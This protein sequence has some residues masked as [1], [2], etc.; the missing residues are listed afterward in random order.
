MLCDAK[1]LPDTHERATT[2]YASY[3]RQFSEVLLAEPGEKN[4]N[5][6][7]DRMQGVIPVE[8]SLHAHASRRRFC[9]TSGGRLGQVP[10]GAAVG[11]LICVFYS[12][13]VPYVIRPVDNGFFTFVGECYVHG[14]MDGEAMQIEGLLEQEFALR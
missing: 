13:S 14:L 2:E 7:K 10:R 1:G 11:D 4:S 8:Q 3:F 5:W 12:G 9:A 6:Y